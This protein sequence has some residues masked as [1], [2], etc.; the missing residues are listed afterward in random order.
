[1]FRY[2]GEEITLLLAKPRS[3]ARSSAAPCG[4]SRVFG[5]LG[6]RVFGV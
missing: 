4:E 6:F 3:G 5:F 1:M 2:E